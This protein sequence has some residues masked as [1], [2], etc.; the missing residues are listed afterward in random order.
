MGSFAALNPSYHVVLFQ[1]RQ[2]G[3]SV[4]IPINL[5]NGSAQPETALIR[6]RQFPSAPSPSNRDCSAASASSAFALPSYAT[7]PLTST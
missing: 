2:D 7:W 3:L 1:F 6:R 4:A 5:R